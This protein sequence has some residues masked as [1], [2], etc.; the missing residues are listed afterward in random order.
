MAI[1]IKKFTITRSK[2]WLSLSA[3]IIII[4]VSIFSTIKILTPVKEE[5]EIALYT[6]TMKAGCNYEVSLIENEIYDRTVMG[7]NLV[8]PKSIFD[9]L[10]VNFYAEF[11]GYP[12]VNSDIRAEY[13]IEAKVRG[14]HT[15]NGEKR[16]VYEETFP[17]TSKLGMKFTD[18]A[19]ISEEVSLDF[20]QYESFINEVKSIL[21]ADPESETELVFRG[22]FESKTKYGNKEEEF[23]YSMALPI[24]QSLF[25]IDKPA[26]IEKTGSITETSLTEKT[27]DR[28]IIIVPGTIILVMLLLIIYILMFST[29]PSEKE[30]LLLRFKA[31]MRKHGSRIVRVNRS[32]NISMDRVLEIKD[33]EGM[34]KISD[35]YNIPIFYKAD[36]G[37]L[38]EDSKFFIPGKDFCCI[39]YLAPSNKYSTFYYL[40]GN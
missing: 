31:I 36:E 15:I 24:F 3:A 5:E 26:D 18:Q 29:M 27:I 40:S 7:E 8:Y 23:A 6:Y 1:K 12:A 22:R 28:F 14:F 37:G 9:K 25:S 20:N 21:Q 4:G 39:Y 2:K 30:I 34:V 35:Q 17:I 32:T 10:K 13:I 38:P 16:I 33:I 19:F 11:I